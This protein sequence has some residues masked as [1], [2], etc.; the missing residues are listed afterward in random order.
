M[1]QRSFD[2]VIIGGGVIGS[3][4]AYFLAAEDAFSGSIVVV[5]KDP[6]YQHCSTALSA[7]GVRQQFSTRANIAISLFG[8]HFLKHLEDYLA[9]DGCVPD[10]GFVENGYLFLTT[11][12]GRAALARN[13]ALQADCGA[14]ISLLSRER[15]AARFPW[16]NTADLAAGAFGERGE[17][18]L[19]PY[20]L[21]RAFS[22]KARSRGVTYLPARL[23]AIHRRGKRIEA[24]TLDNADRLGCGM[25]INAAGAHAARV[26]RLAG[27]N[28][29]PIHCRKRCVYMFKAP[30]AIERCPLVVDPSGAYFRPE[31]D[32]FIAGI[33]PDPDPDCDDFTVSPTLFEE[34][35]WPALAHRVPAFE[36]LRPGP[37]WAGHYAYNVIDQNAILGPHPELTNFVFAN[38]FSGHGLQQSPAVGRYISELIAFGTHKTLDLNALAYTR[39][40]GNRPVAEVN[41]V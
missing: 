2:V 15:L 26:A 41:V 21:L 22:R 39:F 8:A 4:I 1:R 29:L 24:V 28:D 25:V 27:I 35:L 19:D 40:A 7:G 12:A 20:S 6:S 5:E 32:G 14:D 16:L 18:W 17:G 34:R 37:A 31:G 9:V 13:Q 10:V 38:G 3:A 36:A 23:E 33:A 11:A 30:A